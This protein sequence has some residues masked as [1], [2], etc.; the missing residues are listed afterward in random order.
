MYPIY[1][2]KE[3][4]KMGGKNSSQASRNQIFRYKDTKT[5]YQISKTLIADGHRSK[6]I[7]Q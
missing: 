4:Q 1:T 3:E 5:R 6:E 2:L 7:V